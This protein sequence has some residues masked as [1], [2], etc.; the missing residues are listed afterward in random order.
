MTILPLLLSVGPRSNRVKF[1]GQHINAEVCARG[2]RL[3]SQGPLA[4][5]ISTK[6]GFE[7]NRKILTC[8]VIHVIQTKKHKNKII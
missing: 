5:R 8:D 3:Q 1:K 7:L 6:T 2:H 4:D